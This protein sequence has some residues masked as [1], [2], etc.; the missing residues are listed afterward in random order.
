MKN[1]RKNAI[2][3]MKPLRHIRDRHPATANLD[4]LGS[5]KVIGYTPSATYERARHAANRGDGLTVKR[6]AAAC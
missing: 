6:I 5:G 3:I 1:Q 4:P 2:L